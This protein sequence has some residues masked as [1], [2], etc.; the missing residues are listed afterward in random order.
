MR[1]R[2]PRSSF[3]EICG[4]EGIAS[5]SHIH[6]QKEETMSDLRLFVTLLPTFPHF[7]RFASDQRLAGIRMNN[8]MITKQ[9]LARELELAVAALNTVPIYFDVKGRQLRVMEVLEN[10]H[11]L[12][13][14]LNHPISVQTPTPVLF[15]AG[16]DSALL[17]RIEEDGHRLIFYGGP[18]YLVRP[19]ESLYIRHPSLKV[20]GTQF[21]EFERAKIEQVRSSGVI[22]R[23]F[24]SYVES[25]RD[26]DEFLELVGRDTEVMLKIESKAGL[27]YVAREFKKQPNLSLVAARGDLYVELERPH[28]ILGAMQLIIDHDTNAMVGSRLFL[29]IMEQSILETFNAMVRRR[30]E[31]LD[32]D[33][34]L[35]AMREPGVPSC[36]DWHELAWLTKIGYHSMLICDE[37]CVYGSLLSVAVNAFESFRKTY[38]T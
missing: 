16:R 9:G 35:A 22:T 38:S 21:T 8:P 15:K 3:K 23:Y 4:S 26:V 6:N 10:P 36:A 28:E 24:L 14:R 18:E 33:R 17:E 5:P 27:E 20:G 13:F 7:S 30:P 37:I 31:K 2:N 1:A 19:G 29:S 32:Y 11:R 25:Q 12:D 34:L